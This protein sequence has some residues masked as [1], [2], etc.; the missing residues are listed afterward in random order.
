MTKPKR[1]TGHRCADPDCPCGRLFARGTP[2]RAKDFRAAKRTE[3][4]VARRAAAEEAMG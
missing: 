3:R 4:A 2:A 1:P